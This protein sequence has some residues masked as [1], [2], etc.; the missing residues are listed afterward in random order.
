MRKKCLL[1]V[2]ASLTLFSTAAEASTKPAEAEKVTD[3]SEH[4]AESQIRQLQK[5]GIIQG[6][7][8]GKFHPE[9][10]ITRAELVTMF[11][12]AKGIEPA[13]RERVSFADVPQDHWFYPYA[14]TAYRMGILNGEKRGGKLYLQPE[15][16]VTK[17]E[18]ITILLRVRGEAGRVNQLPWSAAMKTLYS[19]PDH[20]AVAEWGR[21]PLVY[22]LNLKLTQPSEAGRLEPDKLVTRA[23]AA[24]YA[25]EYVF[26]P[27]LQESPQQQQE[28]V[29]F[30]YART[31]DV[32]TTAYHYPNDNVKSYLGLPLRPGIVAVDPDVIALGSHLYIEGYGYAVAADIGGAVRGNHVDLYY[33]SRQQAVNHGVKEK[34][35]VYVLD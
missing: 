14:M 17:D 30:R 26:R 12:K 15:K 31:L 34:V 13:A 8:D 2:L 6:G 7:T 10:A 19:Y 35:K 27:S 25:H 23:A 11:V 16:Q 4:W 33:P 20:A 1:A 28:P 3:I 21:R 24:Y 29:P 9:Q 18:L 5:Q 22:A 32:K